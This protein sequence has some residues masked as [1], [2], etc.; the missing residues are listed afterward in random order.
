MKDFLKIS[1]FST[2]VF[3]VLAFFTG[4]FCGEKHKENPVFFIKN[5]IGEIG[6]V[7]EIGRAHV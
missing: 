6:D 3:M 7:Y 2:V 4:A 5:K 1:V